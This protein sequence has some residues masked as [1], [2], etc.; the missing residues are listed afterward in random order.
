MKIDFDPTKSKRNA[1]ERALAFERVAEFNWEE[2]YF[3]NIRNPYPERRFLAI[4]YLDD[5]LHVPCF[6]PINAGVRI[7]SFRKASNREAQDHGKPLTAD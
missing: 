6:S 2:V 5:R 1:R 7:I 4:G 3:D